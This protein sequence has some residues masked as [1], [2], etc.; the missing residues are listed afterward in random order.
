[1]TV[2]AVI[3]RCLPLFLPLVMA[4]CASIVDGSNQSL[5]VETTFKGVA[6]AGA[7]CALT[8]NKGTWFVTTPG[9]VTVHRSYDAMNV[10]CTDAGYTPVILS[11]TS[12]TKGMAFGNLLFGGLIGAGVDMS[13][14]A[15]YDYPKLITVPLDSQPAPPLPQAAQ[16]PPPHPSS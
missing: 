12:S 14:G 11:S 1:V 16:L 15:A 3:G 4:G 13:T 6:V 10:K 7:Q 2:W 8:N 9:T 5:S